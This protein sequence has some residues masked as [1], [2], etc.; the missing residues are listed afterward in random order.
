MQAISVNGIAR[1][2]ATKTI[3][4]AECWI[5]PFGGLHEVVFFVSPPD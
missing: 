4:V 2:L 1:T 3:N 5:R